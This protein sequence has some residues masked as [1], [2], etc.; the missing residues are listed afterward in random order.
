MFVA[1]DNNN[2]GVLMGGNSSLGTAN[3]GQQS[4]GST[5]GATAVSAGNH[6]L[7][8]HPS[9]LAASATLP[10]IGELSSYMYFHIDV[11][12]E[13]FYLYPV[14]PNMIHTCENTILGEGR[15][16]YIPQKMKFTRKSLILD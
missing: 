2:N 5:P 1:E 15:G 6:P 13:H 8:Y 10:E 14:S 9:Q 12:V 7:L 3:G 11:S 4:N 16:S